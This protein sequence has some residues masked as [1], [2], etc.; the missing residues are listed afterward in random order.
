MYSLVLILMIV[1]A[2]LGRSNLKLAIANRQLKTYARGLETAVSDGERARASQD[3]LIKELM[4]ERDAA[5]MMLETVI[6]E[7]PKDSSRVIK[8]ISI[9]MAK[10]SAPKKT[11][12]YGVPQKPQ[13]PP[14]R[15]PDNNQE[16]PLVQEGHPVQGH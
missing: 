14:Q 3:T 12:L 13:V 5:N 4:F 6:N 7:I 15:E 2:F 10:K 9:S 8:S 16:K 11:V 1:A